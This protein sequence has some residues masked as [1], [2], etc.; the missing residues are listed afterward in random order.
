MSMGRRLPLPPPPVVPAQVNT[1]M[2]FH[3]LTRRF[4]KMYFSLLWEFTKLTIT[5]AIN[6][7]IA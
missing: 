3:K 1:V 4:G 6:D 7:L 5:D 2:S